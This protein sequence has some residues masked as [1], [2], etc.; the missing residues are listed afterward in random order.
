MKIQYLD[1]SIV[2]PFLHGILGTKE[3]RASKKNTKAVAYVR[4]ARA[5][6]RISVA[7]YAEALRGSEMDEDIADFIV[8][9]FDSPLQLTERHA[10]RWARLQYRSERVMGD[11]DA[12]NAALAVAENGVVVG[13]DEEAFNDRP[14]L[15]YIDYMKA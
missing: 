5:K 1:T 3:Q 9:E 12:W 10:R 2:I 15:E 11:N 13:H 8:E 4:K 6:L 14:D 7:T